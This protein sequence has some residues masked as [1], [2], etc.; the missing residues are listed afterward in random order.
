MS[1]QL[2]GYDP[3]VPGPTDG[4]GFNLISDQDGGDC[5]F[6]SGLYGNLSQMIAV[7]PDGTPYK[8][9]LSELR[10]YIIALETTRRFEDLANVNF[11]RSPRPGDVVGY[12][13]TTGKW[14]LIEFIT[15]GAW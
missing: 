2:Y 15:G 13:Y 5:Y 14:E 10:D 6:G 9:T 4:R 3:F 1:N 11:T 12:N 7:F 8:Q